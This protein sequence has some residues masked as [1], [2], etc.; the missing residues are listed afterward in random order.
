FGQCLGRT[1][2]GHQYAG[3]HEDDDEGSGPGRPDPP[4]ISPEQTLVGGMSA[5]GRADG[6]G[7]D[8][9]RADDVWA[10]AVRAGRSRVEGIRVSHGRSPFTAG[11][12][13]HTDGGRTGEPDADV[14][15]D[16]V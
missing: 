13:L 4:R 15:C 16:A 3:E 11:G 5:D 6:I 9:I 2:A 12:C 1:V 14:P 10:E 7:A 8:R